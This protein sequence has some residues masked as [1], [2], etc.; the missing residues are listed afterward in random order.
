MRGQ[1]GRE[2][3]AERLRQRGASVDYAEVYSRCIP[4]VDTQPLRQWLS[5]GGLD[6]ATVTS[7]E[8]LRNLWEMVGTLGQDDL[9]RLPLVVASERTASL[10]RA[11]GFTSSLQ[12][13]ADATNEAMQ[14]ALCQWWETRDRP[15]TPG[16]E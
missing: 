7:N 6:V 11:M 2:F 8:T 3:L 5:E 12:V 16:N 13:A 9:V 4:Q 15:R 1:G 10:A 14:A